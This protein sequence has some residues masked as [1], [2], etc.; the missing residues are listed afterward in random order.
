M[1]PADV[2]AAAGVADAVGQ[3]LL[4]LGI[5][6]LVV[7]TG[8]ALTTWYVVRRIRRS[9]RVRAGLERGGLTLRSVARDRSG[10]RLARLR[11]DVRRSAEATGRSLEA[12][13]DRYVGD[14]PFVAADLARV[15]SALD[16]QLRLAEREPDAVV[17]QA[18]LAGLEPRV[19]EHTRLGAE[20]RQALLGGGA[21][22][23]DARLLEAGSRLT[24]EV[25]ALKTWGETFGS[26]RAA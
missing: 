23:G 26:R 19:R 24:V 20:L 21:A 7:I 5:A 17:R 22:A 10:R 12:A 15:G 6:G 16:G 11:L 4:V 13:R 1:P 8:A 14:M 9:R 2:L 3:I 18:L 25:E